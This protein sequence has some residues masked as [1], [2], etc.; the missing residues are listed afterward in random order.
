MKRP[1]GDWRRTIS[2]YSICLG[3]HLGGFMQVVKMGK[4]GAECRINFARHECEVRHI[5]IDQRIG[6]KVVG[7]HADIVAV[8]MGCIERLAANGRR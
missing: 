4:G 7:H 5:P 2:F 1:F 6:Q 8:G 3:S